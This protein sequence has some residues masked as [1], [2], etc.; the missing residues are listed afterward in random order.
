[1]RR[2]PYT[3]TATF[4][5]E[6][7]QLA[8]SLIS[9]EMWPTFHQR[10]E[11]A[12]SSSPQNELT[13]WGSQSHE[14]GHEKMDDCGLEDFRD[15]P[16]HGAAIVF[17]GLENSAKSRILLL[18]GQTRDL[19][20]PKVLIPELNVN[21]WD[22]LVLTP[23]D[24]D[25]ITTANLD[26]I[27]KQFHRAIIVG[28]RFPICRVH[29]RGS[30]TEVSSFDTVAKQDEEK[31]E[32]PFS[33]APQGCGRKDFIL[34]RN[35]LK[36]DFTINSL[37]F[38]PFLNK[39]YD[40]ANGMSDLRSLK[41]QTLIPAK[42]S[43]EEDCARILRGLRIAA[44][45]GLS[46]TEETETAI[47]DLS[48]SIL[49][50]A[51]SRIMMEFN[52]MLSYGAAEPSL[53]L[54]QRFNLLKVVLPVQAAY[55]GQQASKK[56]VQN[57]LMFMKLFSNLDKVV[58]CDHPSDCRLWVGLLAFHLA[59]VNN[60]QDAFVVLAFASILYHGEWKEG[61]RFARENAQVKVNFAPELSGSFTFNSDEELA[62]EVSQLA[63]FVQDSVDVLTET[64]SLFESMSSYPTSPCSGLV[65]VPKKVGQD[66]TVVF[67]LLAK[68]IGCHE[69]RREN[70]EIDYH[71]LGRGF[72][73]ETRFVLGKVILETM[74]CAT[75]RREGE[76]IKEE[77][78]FPRIDIVNGNCDMELSQM[79]KEE[80]LVKKDS[81][82]CILLDTCE[83][84]EKLSKIRKL[85]VSNCS[86]SEGE[87]T[88]ED[89][90]IAERGMCE[91]IAKKR[92]KVDGTDQLH[93][94]ELISVLGNMLAKTRQ[95]LDDDVIEKKKEDVKT[96]KHKSKD[97]TVEKQHIVEEEEINEK[98]KGKVKKK[99][100]KDKDQTVE[101]QHIVEEE[102]V[103]E[104]E[105]GEV[106]KKKRKDKDQTPST[107]VEKRDVPE[108]EVIAK[109]KEDGKKRKSKTDQ[110]PLTVKEENHH[111][112]Q[113]KEVVEKTKED[114]KKKRHGS[115]KDQGLSTVAEK[116]QR[117]LQEDATII[118]GKKRESK[119]KSKSKD[120][121][122]VTVPEKSEGNCKQCLKLLATLSGKRMHYDGTA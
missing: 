51:K 48:S 114:V 83:V 32:L 30:V 87:T 59:L 95:V 89:Q 68:H 58:S 100:R 103:N 71:L 10:R 57:F 53:R 112:L 34:W 40:Y 97:E 4:Y 7:G 70:F 37:F 99:K 81:K 84:K 15:R 22:S 117:E 43:F 41:L 8:G 94:K 101:K 5:F 19:N 72:L 45:L 56:S 122:P 115:S 6:I 2:S 104:R 54:L 63:T 42:V 108:E 119:K 24:F 92:R 35:S 23:K 38:D 16:Q 36:R 44:R 76:T 33:K 62:E 29:I 88:L 66:V 31:E 111:I 65:F 116:Q 78:T 64:E 67:E 39:I 18:N 120:K 50:L 93:R 80:L 17:N 49:N 113:D 85:N 9:R 109:K 52:Y 77:N 86:L 91:D 79:V 26:Q 90:W 28:Q 21:L 55:L 73:W 96:K 47:H 98:E 102:M 60:P 3:V 25:V 46:F 118:K 75:F 61:I 27:K 82:P 105:K 107:V 11:S 1:M 110:R 106:K 12:S 69:K 74:G 121:C 14:R 20:N 13:F